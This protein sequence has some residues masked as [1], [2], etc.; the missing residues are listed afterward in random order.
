[1][2]EITFRGNYMDLIF[3]CSIE[4]GKPGKE[5]TKTKRKKGARGIPGSGGRG[6]RSL[7]GGGGEFRRGRGGDC[8]AHISNRGG[9]DSTGKKEALFF[10]WGGEKMT[11]IRLL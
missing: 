10:P 1:M 5:K 8:F 11:V 9:N 3:Q 2:G 7:S 6:K 4:E